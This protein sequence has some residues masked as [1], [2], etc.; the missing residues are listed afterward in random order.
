LEALF[1]EGRELRVYAFL[2]ALVLGFTV[3]YFHCRPDIL[4]I[5]GEALD[6]GGGAHAAPELLHGV[7]L[8][9]LGPLV[10]ATGLCTIS[11]HRLEV[12][13]KHREYVLLLSLSEQVM[14]T[15]PSW[16]DRGIVGAFAG[17]AHA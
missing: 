2:L 3:P 7:L 8:L 12:A 14:L 4:S 1:L 6:H 11:T 15:M 17:L 5:F 9:H 16:R 13:T 10:I